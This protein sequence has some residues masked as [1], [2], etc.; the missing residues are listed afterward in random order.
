MWAVAWLLTI[1]CFGGRWKQ[2]FINLAGGKVIEFDC[3]L[4]TKLSSRMSD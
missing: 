1:Y 4:T 3:C 2:N